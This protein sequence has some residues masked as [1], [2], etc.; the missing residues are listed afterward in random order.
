MKL[1]LGLAFSCALLWAAPDTGLDDLTINQVQVIGSHNSYKQAIAPALFRLIMA[2]D[3]VHAPAIEY[4]HV[5]LSEQLDLGLRNLEIDVYADEKGGKYAHPKGLNWAKPQDPYDTGGVMNQPG[6]KVFHIQDIDFR[7]SQLTFSGCLRELKAWS[8]KHPNHYPIYIT[9]NAKDEAFKLSP[10]NLPEKF[11][12]AVFDRLDKEIL[13]YL[14]RENLITPDDVRGDY[15][16]LEKAVLAGHWPTMRAARGKF[17]FVLDEHG[18]KRQA[19]IAGHPS[20]KGRVFFADAPVGTPEA[21]FLIM[22]DAKKDSALIRS[23]VQKGYMIRTRADADTKEARANDRSSFEA[24]CASGAQV[25]TTD[26]YYKSTFFPSD[27]KISFENGTY[28]RRDTVFPDKLVTY[29]DPFIGAAGLG[30]IF[31]GPSCPFGMVKPGPDNSMHSNSG[32]SVDPRMPVYGFSQTHVSGTGGG[33]KYGNITIMPFGGDFDSVH[34]TSLRD[35]ETAALGYYGVRL[36]KWNIKTELTASR[37]VAF[38]RFVFGQ[39]GRKGIKIDPGEYLGETPDPDGRENQQFVG[40]ETQ[41]VSPTEI[42]GYSRIRGG[43]NNGAAYT[44]YFS[45]VFNRPAAQRATFRDGKLQPGLQQFDAGDKNG[46]I[47]FFDGG[48]TILVK[49]GI[50][51]IS[52]LKARENIDE[53]TPRWSFEEILHQTQDKWEALLSKIA[54]DGTSDQKVMFYTGLYH[55]MLQPV[56]RTGEN[57]LWQSPLPYYDDFYAIWDTFRSSNPLITLITPSREIDIVNA[58]LNIYHRAGYMPDARSGNDNGRTQGGSNAEVL[59]ADAYVKGLQGIDYEEG[60]RAMLKDANV[61]PGGNEEKEGRGGLT[62]YNTLGYVSN[63]FVRSGN[64]TVEYA[65]DDYCIAEVARGLG[66]TDAY[67][68]FLHQSDNWQN[69]WRPYTDHGSTGFILPRDPSGRWVDSIGCDVLNPRAPSIAYTPLT[70]DYPNC[71]CWWCGFMYEGS[72]WEYSLYAPHDVA[73]LIRK[74]GGAEAF[75]QRLDTFFGNHYFNVTNEPSFLT[76][77][78]YHWI[79]RPDLSSKLVRD[80]I[81]RSYG[82]SMAGLPGNDD[83]GAMSS[84]LDFHMM[85]LYPNAGQSYYLITSPFFASTVVHLEDGK[86]FRIVANHLSDKN[87]Y[88]QSARLN[89]V[90]FGQSWIEHADIVKGG[91]LELE[92]GEAP[93][94][95][96]GGAPPSKS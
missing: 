52:A 83:S 95:W 43:W 41:W 86:T 57:P 16:T 67:E 23:L 29:V 36:T 26:Y 84:W 10:E 88:I 63:R 4:S 76:P 18:E 6:F 91:V 74:T 7:S 27:Y 38:Y 77:V 85:G 11:T 2:K 51:Y 35:Q 1:F 40:C 93:A 69:L 13:D 14:G 96:G 62:D 24:A 80:I 61:P 17:M 82:T 65:Y 45:A 50:S 15:P 92:M 60:F 34:Q 9:M 56:D 87:I 8:D 55:T 20:L 31:I 44:V 89:G 47:A 5:P 81:H 42:R 79:G 73:S 39:K 72:S 58:L 70:R 66:H 54:I 19:Y 37:R 53:E 32:Y 94:G 90:P 21:A 49:F 25:I 12:S 68:R 28:I 33:A 46:A 48:D 71:V 75:Q 78:L 22:N 3:S 30:H 64:R 59:I